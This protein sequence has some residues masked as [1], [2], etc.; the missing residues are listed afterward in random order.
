MKSPAR[1]GA[2]SMSFRHPHR[3]PSSRPNAR[4]RW[5]IPPSGETSRLNFK[6]CMISTG[7]SV[8]IGITKL[9]VVQWGD[10]NPLEVPAAVYVA[11]SNH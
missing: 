11:S 10:G 8:S 9:V 5:L 2:F 6:R 3:I 4:E 1:A 7:R